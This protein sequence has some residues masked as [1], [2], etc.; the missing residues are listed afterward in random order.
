MT[1]RDL[2]TE[3]L[4]QKIEK[5]GGR[6]DAISGTFH[7]LADDIAGLDVEDEIALGEI[8]EMKDRAYKAAWELVHLYENAHDISRQIAWE[9]ER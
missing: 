5:F 8:E 7:D 3:P 2:Y 1:T 4:E 9:D 6:T